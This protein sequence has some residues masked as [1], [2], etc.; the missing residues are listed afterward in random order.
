MTTGGDLLREVRA[1]PDADLAGTLRPGLSGLPA[2]VERAALVAAL[3]TSSSPTDV[4]LIRELTRQEI[5]WVE[6]NDAGCGDVL[7]AC[8]WMLFMGGDVDDAALVWRAK[9]VNFDAHCYIDSALLVPH[10]VAATAEFARS[11]GLTDLA[12]WVDGMLASEL[13]STAEAWRSGEFFRGA[14]SATASLEE[15]AAWMRQ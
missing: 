7:L 2:E 13:Q 12:E 9:N 1:A 4:P 11:R 5:A 8:C 14:P 3:L 15:L 10:G 6:A